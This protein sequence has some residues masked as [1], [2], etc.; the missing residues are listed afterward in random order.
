MSKGVVAQNL[1][2][3]IKKLYKN[4]RRMSGFIVESYQIYLKGFK[5]DSLIDAK[6]TNYTALR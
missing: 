4:K 6:Y 2:E 1:M 5:N 3:G